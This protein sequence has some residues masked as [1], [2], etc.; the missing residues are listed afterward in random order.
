MRCLVNYTATPCNS[1]TTPYHTPPHRA[2]N[3]IP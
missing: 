1:Q 3:T 2:H